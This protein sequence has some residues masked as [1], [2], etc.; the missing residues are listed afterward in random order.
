MKRVAT[1][2]LGGGQGSRLFP[3]TLSRC[4]PALCYGGRFRLIDIPISNAYN[5]GCRKIFV[6]SQYL[7]ASLHRHI[8]STYT[9]GV[10]TN[11]IIELLSSEERPKNRVWFEGTADAIRQ[12]LSYLE[13]A[14]ADYFL[15]L[16]GDQLYAMDFAEMV[17][18]A[19]TTGADAVIAALPVSEGDAT[20]MGIMQVNPEGIITSFHE[21]PTLK[22][23]LERF[24]L[25]HEAGRNF[26]GSMGIYLFSRQ[27]LIELLRADPREDF[28][29]H[30]IPSLV[31]KG[32]VA[33]HIHDGYWEDIGTVDSYHRANMALIRHDSP[34]NLRDADWPVFAHSVSLPGAQLSA[35]A[36]DKTLVCEGSIIEANE[37]SNAIFGPRSTVRS[38]TTIRNTYV[39]GND[40]AATHCSIG[41][42][43]HIENAIID[44]NV[45]IGNGVN[46]LN[47]KSLVQYDGEGVFI[48]DGIIVVPR[49]VVLPDNFVL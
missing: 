34:L 36:I 44:K 10:F 11:G 28:G 47:K 43:V 19:Q 35:L 31:A 48:R 14:D 30:L 22:D 37:L 13:E 39:M 8:F 26:L 9:S 17:R 2:I 27:T 40:A 23:E 4:K 12:N 5:S 42:D 38:G 3:L 16:S 7:S 49:G 45:T 6:I 18:T 20:R 46:L 33:A 41:K 29:K 21:K 24:F 15:I 25:P 32:K 1:V